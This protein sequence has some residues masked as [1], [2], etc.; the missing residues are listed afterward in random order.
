ML[1]IWFYTGQSVGDG[2][3]VAIADALKHN[4]TLQIFHLDSEP[5]NDDVTKFR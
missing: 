5:F 3:A 2:G 1:F 4:S